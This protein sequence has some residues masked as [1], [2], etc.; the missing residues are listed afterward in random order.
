M[1][2]HMNSNGG[3]S[4]G[5]SLSSLFGFGDTFD[6]GENHLYFPRE[7]RRVVTFKT[8]LEYEEAIR[9]N[10]TRDAL[11]IAIY[12]AGCVG[13]AIAAKEADDKSTRLTTGMSSAVCGV[14]AASSAYSIFQRH[15]RYNDYR[16]Q[17]G[18]ETKK[19]TE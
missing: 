9:E 18:K 7:S 19:P 11:K 17:N 14:Y 16:K 12:G 4:L 2:L 13:L 15:R 3:V 10:D 6:F 5:G 1:Y 8:D